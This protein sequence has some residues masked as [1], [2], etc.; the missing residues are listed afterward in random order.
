MSSTYT[1]AHSNAR[2]LTSW[3]RPG[4]E[5]VSSWILVRF[6]TTEPWQKLLFLFVHIYQTGIVSPLSRSWFKTQDNHRKRTPPRERN[7]QT[8]VLCWPLGKW[9]AW[10]GKDP[11]LGGGKSSQKRALQLCLPWPKGKEGVGKT[12]WPSSQQPWNAVLESWLCSF[13]AL[14]KQDAWPKDHP[15]IRGRQKPS[16]LSSTNVWW[17][18]AIC[19]ETV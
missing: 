12:S 15:S 9:R 7:P 6:I 2:S 8:E 13:P 10:S 14:T 5:P 11:P 16:F 3:T 18:P 19:Q 17:A 1:A 4:I